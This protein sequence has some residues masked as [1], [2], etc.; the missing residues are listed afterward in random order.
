MFQLDNPYYLY[1]LALLPLLVL[2]HWLT[3]RWRN[4][5]L[6]AYGDIKIIKQL[7][8]DVSRVKRIWKFVLFTLTFL[9]LIIGIVNPQAG[10]KLQDIKRTGADIM[11]CLDVSNSMRAED[12]Q[13]NRLEKS[14]RSITKL[15][16]KLK[17]DRI[18]II[19]FGAQA[20]VQLP[21]TTDYAASKLFLETISTDMIPTQGTDIGAAINLAVES[22]GKD[23]GKNKAIIIITDGE[24]HE[25]RAIEAA[26][27]AN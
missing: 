3:N 26:E 13:P 15:I 12:I 24:N 17:G 5:A 10:S 23:E 9:F 25:S 16:D 8:P 27:Q 20:Y 4:K 7:F 18:G 2:K 22:F 14:K 21:I 1:A 11:I 6:S 19:V